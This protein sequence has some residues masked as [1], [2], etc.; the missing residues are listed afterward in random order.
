MLRPKLW[1]E[2]ALKGLQC[3]RLK[4]RGKLAIRATVAG[5][6]LRT[7]IDLIDLIGVGRESIMPQTYTILYTKQKTQKNKRWAEGFLVVSG[8]GQ[9]KLLDEN[10]KEVD[11]DF[12]SRSGSIEQGEEIEFDRF[13]VEVDE[14]IE[15]DGPP[16]GQSRA[17]SGAPHPLPQESRVQ[18][19][20][21]RSSVRHRSF[22]QPGAV[23]PS[24]LA[25]SAPRN[26]R[27]PGLFPLHP[28]FSFRLGVQAQ[29]LDGG[30][31]CTNISITLPVGLIRARWIMLRCPS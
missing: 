15:G 26:I 28:R 14:L 13:L 31:A 17:D 18:H 10:R 16:S 11:C 7:C 29:L 20:A 6:A 30:L 1:D 19:G 24:P 21:H 8:F 12:R 5:A 22:S 27:S 9:M 3:W 4:V 2:L 25:G 23:H